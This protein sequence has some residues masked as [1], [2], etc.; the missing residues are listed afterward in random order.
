MRHVSGYAKRCGM[1][2]AWFGIG[3]F[4]LIGLF[5]GGGLGLEAGARINE[6]LS[7]IGATDY[8]LSNLIIVAS[9]ATGIITA[10]AILVYGSYA[11]FWAAGRIFERISNR[12][13]A[14]A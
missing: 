11:A 5:F 8:F 14:V 4:S 3:F 9:A 12:G 6:A 1:A 2:G 7:S 13:R 10:T